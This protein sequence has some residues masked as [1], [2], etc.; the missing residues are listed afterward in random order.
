MLVCSGSVPPGTPLDAYAQLSELAARA[1][2]V[3]IVDVSG[4]ALG[5]ALQSSSRRR[6][7]EPR[8]SRGT[9]ART[10]RRD[11]RGR[12]SGRGSAASGACRGRT[13]P[14]R[15]EGRGRDRRR[16][17]RSRGR[18]DDGPVAPA[19]A[20]TVRNPVGAGDALVGGL[21]AALERG[22]SLEYAVTRGHRNAPPRAWRPTRPARSP[23]ARDRSWRPPPRLR[24]WSQASGGRDRDRSPNPP[25]TTLSSGP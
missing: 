4:R 12:R 25:L 7:P 8:R 6:L 2:A 11:G 5:A 17:G 3:A 20:V 15:R 23:G 14:A 24:S 13:G 1:N 18:R 22:E 19:H 21:A 10:R 9:A 16:G